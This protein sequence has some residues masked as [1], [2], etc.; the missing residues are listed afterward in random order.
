MGPFMFYLVSNLYCFDTGKRKAPDQQTT[1]YI[2][3]N[4]DRNPTRSCKNYNT[5][6]RWQPNATARIVRQASLPGL[7][8]GRKKI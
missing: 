4:G 3:H 2:D 8:V 1:L 7:L 6:S 5:T